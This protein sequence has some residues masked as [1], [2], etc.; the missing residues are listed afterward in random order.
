VRHP[1]QQHGTPAVADAQELD[2]PALGGPAD[3][4]ETGEAGE[5]VDEG[6]GPLAERPEPQELLVLRNPGQDVG[7]V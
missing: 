1:D 7:D 2:R 5:L 6:T 4:F 3:R